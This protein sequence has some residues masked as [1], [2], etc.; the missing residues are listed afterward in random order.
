MA[1]IAEVVKQVVKDNTQKTVQVD[2][3]VELIKERIFKFYYRAKFKP[4][5]ANVVADSLQDAIEKCQEYCRR[6]NLRFISV[7][8]FFLELNPKPENT[9]EEKKG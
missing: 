6:N 1:N 2:N 4:S 3:L 5:E 7:I 9:E 8:P